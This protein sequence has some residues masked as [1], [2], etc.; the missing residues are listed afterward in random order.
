MTIIEVLVAI[1]IFAVA[2]GILLQTMTSSQRA[3]RLEQEQMLA[4]TAGQS[5]LEELRNTPFSAVVRQYD[6]DP[7]NDVLGPGTAP[8]ATFDVDGLVPRDGDADGIC[9]EVTLPVVNTGSAVAPVWE[10][11]EDI[12]EPRLGLPRD[13][14]GDVLVDGVDHAD[15]HSLLPVMV[16]VGWRGF[17]GD[18]EIRLFTALTRY[19]EGE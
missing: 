5:V 14:N 16:T 7:F 12:G 19:G 4:M 17:G 3:R 18:R 9:G 6:P 8:G 13:L 10:V 2:T 1:A 15:D 11:R